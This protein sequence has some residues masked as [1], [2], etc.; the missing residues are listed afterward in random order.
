M[1]LADHIIE[2]AE[3]GT[4]SNPLEEDLVTG[5]KRVGL[6]KMTEG[7]KGVNYDVIETL[8]NTLMIKPQD[9]PDST[10]EDGN[11]F[12]LTAGNGDGTGTGG[13][14]NFYGG[15][16]EDTGV[17]A[18]SGNGGALNFCGGG[19]GTGKNGG[20]LTLQAG[21]GDDGNGGNYGKIELLHPNDMGTGVILDTTGID[22]AVSHF[23]TQTFPDKD[24]TFAMTSD[25]TTE[26]NNL[27]QFSFFMSM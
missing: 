19:G 5:D 16:G 2:H 13:V 12:S 4:P 15:S 10:N 22:D 27:T 6:I 25:I 14:I 8:N 9:A 24:G 26:S 11:S 17:Q 3:L 21:W 18:T 1:A 23:H 7:V 20:D